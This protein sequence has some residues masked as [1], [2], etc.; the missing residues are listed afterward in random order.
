MAELCEYC[1]DP[2]DHDE[3]RKCYPDDLPDDIPWPSG[4]NGSYYYHSW[5][6]E[7]VVDDERREI[8]IKHGEG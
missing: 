6:W 3:D 7:S 2:I 8:A 5:C 4:N 1:S